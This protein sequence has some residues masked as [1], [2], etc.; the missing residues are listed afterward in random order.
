MLKAF[1]YPS[2][3]SCPK[4]FACD[5]S[6]LCARFFKIGQRHGQI[7]RQNSCARKVLTTARGVSLHP[8]PSIKLSRVRSVSRG[9]AARRRQGEAG[10][11]LRMH[12]LYVSAKRIKGKVFNQK[13]LLLFFFLQISPFSFPCGSNLYLGGP[14]MILRNIFCREITRCLSENRRLEDIRPVK[15]LDWM[16]RQSVFKE[17]SI[18][19]R[20]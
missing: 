14:N 17:T 1:L 7:M 13:F 20:L 3:T 12:V 5:R 8:P 6:L 16:T 10:S 2:R 18:S 9:G 11:V 15:L 19:V 4:R